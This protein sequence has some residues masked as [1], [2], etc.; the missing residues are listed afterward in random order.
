MENSRIRIEKALKHEITDKL[1]V[2]FGGTFQ[3]GIH[4]SVIA[5]LREY[6]NLDD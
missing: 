6:F 3:T 5:K 1:P 2:D 4:V